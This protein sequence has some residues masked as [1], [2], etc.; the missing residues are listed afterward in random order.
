MRE[1]SCKM[2]LKIH[3]RC[4]P[5]SI[6]PLL[7]D[8]VKGK[9]HEVFQ[10]RIEEQLYYRKVG[11]DHLQS[12]TRV[13]KMS[14]RRMIRPGSREK[15]PFPP[16]RPKQPPKGHKERGTPLPHPRSQ[17]KS[18]LE[19]GW[20]LAFGQVLPLPGHGYRGSQHVEDHGHSTKWP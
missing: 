9:L 15:L 14:S 17:F 18:E 8:F 2:Q 6:V 20:A 16:S 3:V 19:A 12:R 5:N 11:P 10:W 7:W 1:V 4:N 13:S